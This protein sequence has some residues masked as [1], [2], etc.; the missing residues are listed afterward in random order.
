[1]WAWVWACTQAIICLHCRNARSRHAQTVLNIYRDAH[2]A[3]FLF[4]CLWLRVRFLSLSCNLCSVVQSLEWRAAANGCRAPLL[5]PPSAG[6][7]SAESPPNTL[8]TPKITP[9]NPPTTNTDD[10]PCVVNTD[11]WHLLSKTPSNNTNS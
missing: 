1:M 8:R 10:N 3:F 2:R 6:N 11:C 4:Q 9:K 5:L 7:P